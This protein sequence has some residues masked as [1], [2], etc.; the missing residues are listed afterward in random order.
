MIFESNTNE[1]IMKYDDKRLEDAV[2]SAKYYIINMYQNG[3][4]GRSSRDFLSGFCG[5]FALILHNIFSGRAQI[6]TNSYHAIVKVGNKFYDANDY[7]ITSEVLPLINKEYFLDD[8]NTDEGRDHFGMF[9]SSCMNKLPKEFVESH[10]EEMKA[11]EEEVKKI[12]GFEYS[13]DLSR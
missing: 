7:D 4:K 8:L 9:M 6:Y 2:I 10:Q 1:S 12:M 11:I 3:F 5:D 13:K